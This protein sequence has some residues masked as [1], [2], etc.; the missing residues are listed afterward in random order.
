[1]VRGSV[2]EPEPVVDRK[3]T[4]SG[5]L[6]SLEVLYS[7]HMVAIEHADKLKS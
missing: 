7:E 2:A 4:G 1:M 3:R 6:L 5:T